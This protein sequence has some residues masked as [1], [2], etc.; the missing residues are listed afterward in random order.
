MALTPH[1]VYKR[2][3]NTKAANIPKV[4][5]WHEI[6]ILARLSVKVP[7]QNDATPA[8]FF[9]GTPKHMAQRNAQ[10]HNCLTMCLL[11]GK[12]DLEMAISYATS[13][14]QR[15]GSLSY[16]DHSFNQVIIRT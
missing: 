9:A 2:Y 11:K 5:L 10:P 4:K 3:K 1:S 12:V 6:P 8:K 13:A 15:C 16:I 14:D 7:S